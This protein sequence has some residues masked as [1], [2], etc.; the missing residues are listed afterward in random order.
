MSQSVT[1]EHHDSSEKTIFGFWVYLM[2]D[3]VMF[4]VLFAAYAVL[5]GNTNG[6]PS[7]RELFDLPYVL[8]ETVILLTSSFACCLAGLAAGAKRKRQMLAWFG[9]TF[10]LGAAFLSMEISEYARLAASGNGWQRNAFLS[11]YFTLAGT[12]VLH[13]AA[14]LLW[15]AVLLPPL[16][17]KRGISAVALKRITCL[18]MFWLFLNVVWIFVF[19]LV[20]L[21]GAV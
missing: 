16:M 13:I 1:A 7:G 17:F 15:M 5:H 10:L 4:G 18:R 8:A 12:H 2:T 11:S 3:C 21:M 14:G 6:G 19:T 20:Y 9:V